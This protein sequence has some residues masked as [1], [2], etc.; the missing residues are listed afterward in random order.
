MRPEDEE[1]VTNTVKGC[2]K[3]K[4]SSHFE[5]ISVD[6]VAKVVSVICKPLT[7]RAHQ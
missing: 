4:K 7:S 5:H 6:T 2:T 3:K 1:V